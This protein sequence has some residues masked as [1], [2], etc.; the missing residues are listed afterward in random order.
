MIR[1]YL[2]KSNI[3]SN[4]IKL[5]KF[6]PIIYFLIRDNEIV[7]VGQSKHGLHRITTHVNTNKIQFDSYSYI[8]V[9]EEDM[10]KIEA[11]YILKFCPEYNKFLPNNTNEYTSISK[12][13][14]M[15]KD[16][17][18]SRKRFINKWIKMKKVNVYFRRYFKTKEI[19]KVIQEEMNG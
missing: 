1:F 2:T 3:I 17:G 14:K 6:P 11:F 8:E 10:N 4:K 13:K 12:T 18:W 7:Y 16:L 9:K 19:N 15:L 5:E